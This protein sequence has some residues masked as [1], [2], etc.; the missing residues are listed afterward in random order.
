MVEQEFLLAGVSFSSGGG[1]GTATHTARLFGG[2]SN[3]TFGASS[4]SEWIRYPSIG[5]QVSMYWLETQSSV[6]SVTFRG[7]VAPMLAGMV[8]TYEG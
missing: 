5:S 6:E 3:A 4:W 8:A 7:T 1:E 2:Q